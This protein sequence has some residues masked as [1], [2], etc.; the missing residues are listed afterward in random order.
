MQKVW[1]CVIKQPM[2]DQLIWEPKA[3]QKTYQHVLLWA[4]SYRPKY[5][6]SFP[7]VG[8]TP[9]LSGTTLSVYLRVTPTSVNSWAGPSLLLSPLACR[10][11][12]VFWVAQEQFLF[13][14]KRNSGEGKKK[15]KASLL[16]S[17]PNGAGL[18]TA[19]A[20]SVLESTICRWSLPRRWDPASQNV[21]AEP[22]P[23]NMLLPKTNSQ[24]PTSTAAK[25]QMG[26][27]SLHMILNSFFS[28][29]KWRRV[30]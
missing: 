1:L 23:G 3:H 14:Q 21:V 12:Q 8:D 10:S 28:L 27:F 7:G 29:A 2:K 18:G 5:Q 30:I 22:A 26:S 6:F 19:D 15:K 25:S 11:V 13:G 24:S 20:D 4:P 17:F 16:A 9:E